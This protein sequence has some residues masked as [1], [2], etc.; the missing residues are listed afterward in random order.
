MMRIGSECARFD[1]TG[2]RAAETG[3]MTTGGVLEGDEGGWGK[4]EC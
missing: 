3:G 1:S 2:S 4:G